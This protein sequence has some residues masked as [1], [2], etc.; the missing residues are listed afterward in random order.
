MHGLG[1]SED[2]RMGHGG[3]GNTRSK[4]A[5]LCGEYQRCGL[6]VYPEKGHALLRTGI[7]A[8][9]IQLPGTIGQ[10]VMSGLRAQDIYGPIMARSGAWYR[11][12]L[13]TM[14]CIP[15][16]WPTTDEQHVLRRIGATI[17]VASTVFRLP[18]G[19]GQPWWV[20]QPG[21]PLPAVSTVLAFLSERAP[22]LEQATAARTDLPLPV[23]FG[24]IPL[25]RWT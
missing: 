18:G 7:A 3:A 12:E 21:R 8:T 16:R 25:G 22:Q 13:W 17:C 23:Q 24:E 2:M 9:A 10:R 4:L 6:P 1:G 14:L 15:D 11:Q 5:Q 20:T 19:G